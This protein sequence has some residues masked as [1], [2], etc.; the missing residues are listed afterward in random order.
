MR[1]PGL[2]GARQGFG[3]A[4]EAG[5][6][7]ALDRLGNSMK[8]DPHYARD[9]VALAHDVHRL[10]TRLAGVDLSQHA[11]RNRAEDCVMIEV[12]THRQKKS[13]DDAVELIIEEV[14]PMAR[15]AGY[16]TVLECA[17]LAA[18]LRTLADEIEHYHD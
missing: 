2:K 12:E 6:R 4:G 11:D 18:G 16:L 5:A 15:W 7:E 8:A 14:L 10:A 3:G 17:R 1:V 9:G 13:G